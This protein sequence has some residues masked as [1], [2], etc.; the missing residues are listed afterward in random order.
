MKDFIA[1][2]AAKWDVG[3]S[4]ESLFFILSKLFVSEY[5]WGKKKRQFW[6]LCPVTLERAGLGLK[7]VKIY[8]TTWWNAD[9]P[10][11]L[12]SSPSESQLP[13]F[14]RHSLVM[15]RLLASLNCTPC[16]FSHSFSHSFSSK[17]LNRDT[18]PSHLEPIK[19][20][21]GNNFSILFGL[22]KANCFQVG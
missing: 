18:L 4:K 17:G 11:R 21:A 14:Y 5:I 1:S 20:F 8:S 13:R 3:D 16:A 6:G 19:L 12:P 2:H 15:I 10:N 22:F 7:R 9:S